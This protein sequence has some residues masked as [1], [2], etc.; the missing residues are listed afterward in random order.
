[1]GSKN[2]ATNVYLHD[3]LEVEMTEWQHEL[4]QHLPEGR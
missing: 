2:L 4:T 1:M 3:G